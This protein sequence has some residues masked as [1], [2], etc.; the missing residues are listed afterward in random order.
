MIEYNSDKQIKIEKFSTPFEMKMDATVAADEFNENDELF[1]T[2]FYFNDFLFFFPFFNLTK[3]T[4][5]PRLA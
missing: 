4:L 2:Q 5:Y 3:S 1:F